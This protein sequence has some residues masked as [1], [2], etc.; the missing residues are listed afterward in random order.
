[1]KIPLQ[2][3]RVAKQTKSLHIIAIFPISILNGNE[4]MNRKSCSIAAHTVAQHKVK[5]NQKHTKN[6]YD[7]KTKNTWVDVFAL[8]W[9]YATLKYWT[10]I[11]SS[12]RSLGMYSAARGTQSLA[13]RPKLNW[14]QSVRSG[15]AEAIHMILVRLSGEFGKRRPITSFGPHK[16]EKG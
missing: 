11:D 10:D 1:M 8:G 14:L 9:R 12:A 13:L 15:A 7:G 5:Q 3:E 2:E 16:G 4:N 6:R